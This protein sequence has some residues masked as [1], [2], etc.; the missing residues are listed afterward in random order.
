MIMTGAVAPKKIVSMLRMV[1]VVEYGV[2]GGGWVGWLSEWE[3]RFPR[4]GQSTNNATCFSTIVTL[5]VF[6]VVERAMTMVHFNDDPNNRNDC[7]M[8]EDH[9]GPL[10]LAVFPLTLLPHSRYPPHPPSLAGT[11]RPPHC[12]RQ[13]TSLT[14]SAIPA[15]RGWCTQPP[16]PAAADN[17]GHNTAAVPFPRAPAKPCS[18]LPQPLVA[19]HRIDPV[20]SPTH[21]RTDPMMPH[22]PGHRP[23]RLYRDPATAPR[24][25]DAMGMASDD[26]ATAR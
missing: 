19:R 24:C 2:G 8:M 1:A 3:K 26:A 23:S 11:H 16:L 12:T 6:A 13:H 4:S 14:A 5:V 17:G 9:S 25:G 21:R 7:D 20:P 15:L 10:T 18:S 22:L